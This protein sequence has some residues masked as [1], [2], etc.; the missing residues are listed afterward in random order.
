MKVALYQLTS[1]LDWKVNLEKIHKAAQKAS[2]E[3]CKALFLPECFFSMS[4]G[5]SPTP[6]L[7]EQNNEFHQEIRKI[8][9]QN[10][11]AI[12]GGSAAT[13]KNGVVVNRAYNFDK[14]G[15]DL[16]VY[17]KNH[18]FSCDLGGDKKVINEADI[19]TAG[20]ATQMIQFE[21]WKIGLGICFDLRYPEMARNYVLNGASIL[22]FSSAFTVP[23]GKAHWHTL[24]RARAIENQC[25]VIAVGQWGVHNER[26]QTYGHSLV[27]D[28][29]GD[30][31]LDAGEGEG[32]HM[33]EIDYNKI[34]EVRKKVKVF[35]VN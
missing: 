7:I 14:N 25:Y 4:N 27:I 15:I 16:G 35:E 22:T 28:P 21:E 2:Q 29:W 24:N 5:Q 19:Y 20:N 26:I 32:L 31:L 1:V 6:Y 17:D 30:I 3:N 11:I 12:I 10:N 33:V 34:D 13:L 23:T 18:L 9:T 8:S